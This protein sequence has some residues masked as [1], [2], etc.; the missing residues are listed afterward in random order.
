MRPLIFVVFSQYELACKYEIIS[1]NIY[2]DAELHFL[3]SSVKI[4]NQT[5]Y[6]R[7]LIQFTF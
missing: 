6:N 1:T 4:A 3:I 5:E 2:L 7:N